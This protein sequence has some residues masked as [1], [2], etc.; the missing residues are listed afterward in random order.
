[1]DKTM[2]L[3]MIQNYYKLNKDIEFA[4][5]LGISSQVLSNWK[6]RNT[7]DAQL[8]YTKCLNI[9]P[10]WLLTG[11]DPM[12]KAALQTEA[13]QDN[14]NYKELAEARLEII[15]G[16]K[17]KVKTLEKELSELKYAQKETFLYSNV[18]E[19]TPELIKKTS[20]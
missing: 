19:S 10:E 11:K 2:M 14:I 4:S 17:F 12:F 18:A 13:A 5:L 9:N 8:I 20:K 6:K 7:F 1:M 3:N 16:L 15:E